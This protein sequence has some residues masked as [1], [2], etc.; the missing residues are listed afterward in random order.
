MLNY[1]LFA[2][3]FDCGSLSAYRSPVNLHNREQIPGKAVI[4]IHPYF[5]GI[6]LVS[7]RFCWHPAMP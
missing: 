7:L 6:A 4:S 2:A 5:P 1:R 3:W